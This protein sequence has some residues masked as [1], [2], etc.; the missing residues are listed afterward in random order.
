[1][2]K[3]SSKIYHKVLFKHLSKYTLADFKANKENV[4]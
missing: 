2:A 3:F 4:K 1:M